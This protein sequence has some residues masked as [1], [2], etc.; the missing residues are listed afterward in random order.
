MRLFV[1]VELGENIR[2][3]AADAGREFQR[4]LGPALKARWVPAENMHLT[5]RFIGHVDNTRAEIIL[6]ALRPP[7]PV[8]PFDIELGSCGVF[9]ASGSPRA[10]W[11][12]LAAGAGSLGAMHNEFNRRLRP[13]GYD[14]E[15]RSFNVHLTLARFKDAP[16]GSGAAVRTA[17]QGIVPA[18]ARCPVTQATVFQSILSPK[19]ATYRS[20]L[21]V[22]CE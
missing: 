14:P 12:G 11:I 18:R 19:G 2:A 9:P 6:E 22:E 1:A 16:R 5:V 7:L 20:L 13:L 3:A 8:P 17:A 10:L 21:K 15:D 4:R